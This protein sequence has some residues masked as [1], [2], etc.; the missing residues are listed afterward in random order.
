MTAEQLF[1]MKQQG[2]GAMKK[3]QV[4][5]SLKGEIS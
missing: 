3:L 4:I 2:D 5:N 1:L